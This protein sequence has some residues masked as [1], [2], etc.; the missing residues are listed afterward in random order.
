MNDTERLLSTSEAAHYLGLDPGTLK[1]WRTKGGGPPFSK[2]SANRAR[3]SLE[4]LKAW[5]AERTR[6]STSV[7]TRGRAA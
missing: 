1:R 5:T 2:V 7:D 4:A 3:Y 6:R